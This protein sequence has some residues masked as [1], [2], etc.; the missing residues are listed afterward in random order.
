MVPSSIYGDT[1]WA[2]ANN[3]SAL[4]A[5]RCQK[6]RW[7]VM[8]M[9]M[10]IYLS[11]HVANRICDFGLGMSLPVSVF[12]YFT[13]CRVGVPP[14]HLYEVVVGFFKVLAE[15]LFFKPDDPLFF[16]LLIDGSS[17]DL[18]GDIGIIRSIFLLESLLNLKY[19][20]LNQ[21]H[22]TIYTISYKCVF[23]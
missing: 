21:N 8:V 3:T 4:F 10:S 9:D 5:K 11:W 14:S 15:Y 7:R 19:G 2:A 22:D 6:T 17:W 1:E 12:V 18:S 13:S 23:L 16:I 20:F